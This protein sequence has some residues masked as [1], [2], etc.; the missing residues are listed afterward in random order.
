MQERK[1]NRSIPTYPLNRNMTE[2]IVSATFI[3]GIGNKKGRFIMFDKIILSL[4]MSMILLG[5]AMIAVPIP[6]LWGMACL[7]FFA[8]AAI[9]RPQQQG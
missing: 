2:T 6:V 3:S 1:I 7:I 9:L 4:I 8:L 5:A